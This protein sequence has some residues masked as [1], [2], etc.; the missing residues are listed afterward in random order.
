MNFNAKVF[1]FAVLSFSVLI[2]SACATTSMQTT[3]Q[4]KPGFSNITDV[5]IPQSAH[6]NLNKS[7]VMGGGNSWTGHLVYETNRPQAEVIDFMN[8]NM[9][10]ADWTKISESRAKDTVITFMK[11]KR[12]A[13][14]RILNDDG[15]LSKQTT[16]T[17]DM[18]NSKL[19]S[20]KT[21]VIKDE[22]NE[23]KDLT[24]EKNEV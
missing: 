11:E 14:I 7:M 3:A 13:T 12:V 10:Q 23:E 15:Y 16:V 22:P 24:N 5:P 19:R 18:A 9:Q 20:I 17:I 2:L 1:G 4:T 21:A 6:M 8:E